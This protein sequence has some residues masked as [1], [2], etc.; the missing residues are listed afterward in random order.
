MSNLKEISFVKNHEIRGYFQVYC[1]FTMFS[2]SSRNPVF[3]INEPHEQ[4]FHL[5]DQPS[6][7]LSPSALSYRDITVPAIPN[8]RKK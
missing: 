2:R 7:C 8:K 6:L 5:L 3:S 4:S 1:D